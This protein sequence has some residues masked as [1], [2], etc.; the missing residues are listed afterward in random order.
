MYMYV[1]S[2]FKHSFSIKSRLRD[3]KS[4][5]RDDISHLDN[6]DKALSQRNA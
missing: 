2:I 3:S 4:Y 1:I 5:F 6:I